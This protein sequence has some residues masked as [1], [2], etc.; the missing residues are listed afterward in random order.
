MALTN[1]TTITAVMIASAGQT[2]FPYTNIR[3]LVETDLEVSVDGVVKT[4][5]TDY[6]VTGVGDDVGGTVVFVTPMVGAEEVVIRRMPALTQITTYPETTPFPSSSHEQ[7]LDKLTMITQYLNET[8]ERTPKW[9]SSIDKTV[10][11]ATLPDP[12]T[13]AGKALAFS[14]T[15]IV[16]LTITSSDVA[17]PLTTKG[18]L[19]VYGASAD[20]LAIGTNGSI[21]TPDSAQALGMKWD[22]VANILDGL[23]TTR[24]DIA[25]VGSSTTER[26]ALGN[27]HEYLGSDGTDILYRQLPWAQGQCQLAKSGA[28]LVLSPY[29]G[30]NVILKTGTTWDRHTI[31]SGGVSLAATGLTPSTLYYIYLYNNAGTL[32]MEASTTGYATETTYGFTVKSGDSTRLLVGMAWVITGPA[33]EDTATARHVR[34]W[35]H[36]P[37]L[38]GVGTYTTDRFTASPSYAV[39]NSEI[40]I[41]LLQWTGEVI[42]AS[43]SGGCKV[44]GSANCAIAIAYDATPT[45]LTVGGT[46]NAP[47]LTFTGFHCRSLV[48]GLAEGRH[49]LTV[50]AKTSANN[51]TLFGGANDGAVALQYQIGR[52]A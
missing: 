45:V 14:A 26:L 25:R 42:D 6:T 3:I 11:G 40:E 50:V 41:A 7:A 5:T 36:D 12:T 35:F 15:G 17:S 20:R 27:T 37:V 48:S 46:A 22:T 43:I 44:N 31:P 34:S 39:V 29:N 19:V 30:N 8:D 38:T 2:V 33:F 47:L 10:V 9:P 4:L 13:N 52:I 16:P 49:T 24:G 18:D 23:L 28:A 51:L 32:T 21:L 1:T